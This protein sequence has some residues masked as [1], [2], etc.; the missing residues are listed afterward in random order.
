MGARLFAY[1]T[2]IT[3][4]PAAAVVHAETGKASVTSFSYEVSDL[5]PN[6]GIA[7]SLTLLP[8]TGFSQATIFGLAGGNVTSSKPN[9]FV[10]TS[11]DVG[12][13][14]AKI[15][16]NSVS[17]FVHNAPFK[18]L[19]RVEAETG[20]GFM[21]TP[22]TQVKFTGMGH[23]DITDIGA[24]SFFFETANIG[25]FLS[26]TQFDDVTIGTNCSPCQTTGSL[27]KVLFVTFANDGSTPEQAF[28][29]ANA[30]GEFDR[31][32]GP[33]VPEPSEFLLLAFGFAALAGIRC[34]N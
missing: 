9:G 27:D 4:N 6:D 13:A 21:L 5:D 7:P 23:V 2:L 18:E 12:V 25:V 14:G 20:F 19:V 34:M 26:E 1:A 17:S 11:V 28:V 22:H 3:L 16:A 31:P 33:P 10:D 15:T 24:S 29:G 32:I 30:V 8:D